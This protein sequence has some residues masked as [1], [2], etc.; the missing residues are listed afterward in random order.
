MKT[1]ILTAAAVAMVGA[2]AAWSAVIG[3]DPVSSEQPD[4][5]DASWTMGGTTTRSRRSTGAARSPE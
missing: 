1:R 3:Y 2:S 5:L 4:A